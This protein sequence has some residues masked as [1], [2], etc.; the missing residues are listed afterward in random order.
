AERLRQE[1]DSALETATQTIRECSKKDD[2]NRAILLKKELELNEIIQKCNIDVKTC[3]E[4]F[5]VEKRKFKDEIE[6]LCLERVKLQTSLGMLQKEKRSLETELR[7]IKSL[8]DGR[9]RGMLKEMGIRAAD[10]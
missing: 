8:A 5:E 6:E 3:R 4:N 7:D 2:H 10:M 1:R 9:T